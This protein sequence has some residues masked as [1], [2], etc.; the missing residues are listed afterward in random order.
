MISKRS[1][2]KEKPILRAGFVVAN[3]PL[4]TD[5]VFAKLSMI[6][7]RNHEV[8]RPE[9][10]KG[11]GSSALRIHGKMF[12]LLSSKKEFVVKLPKRRVD[13]LVSAGVGYRFDPRRNGKVMKEWLVVNSISES[14]RLSLAREAMDFALKQN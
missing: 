11:F 13:K 8:S 1:L 7:L 10:K 14:K 12:A 4:K 2:L 9:G 5:E 6:L 3:S